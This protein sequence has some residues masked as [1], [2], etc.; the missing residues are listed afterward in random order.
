MAYTKTTFEQL[1]LSLAY[2]YGEQ[3]IPSSDT[4]NRNHWLNKGVQ[5]IAERLKL[6]KS[7]TITVTS[8]VASL[9]DDFK[10]I[11]RVI[12]ADNAE[13][14]QENNED[15]DSNTSLE[16]F[17]IYGNPVDGYFI[18]SKQDGQFTIFYY[19]FTE[20]MVNNSD[21]CIIPDGEAVVCYSYA[22]IRKSETDPLG[23]AQ[24]NIEEMERRIDLMLEDKQENKARI[25]MRTLN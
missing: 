2:K 13:V 21:I 20:D 14:G 18:R 7:A 19:F 8:G 3:S 15:F 4:A 25:I 22:M 16:L 17:A 6:Q 24:Q 1:Q 9:P 10:S 12:N 5:Y 23:D 11:L